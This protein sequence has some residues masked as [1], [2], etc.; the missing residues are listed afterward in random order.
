MINI[1]KQKKG[2]QSVGYRTLSKQFL[3]FV[4]ASLK[5][6]GKQYSLGNACLTF[7]SKYEKNGNHILILLLSRWKYVRLLARLNKEK[8]LFFCFSY[9]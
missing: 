9:K 8:K 6:S 5:I 7:S 2:N 4:R 3:S 1:G